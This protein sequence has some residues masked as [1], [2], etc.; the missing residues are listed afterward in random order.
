VAE[1]Y[2]SGR[3]AV[4]VTNT[5]DV[6]DEVFA[7]MADALAH[8]AHEVSVSYVTLPLRDPTG[9]LWYFAAPD[10]PF[11]FDETLV[12]HLHHQVREDGVRLDVLTLRPEDQARWPARIAT[13]NDLG[14]TREPTDAQRRDI[15]RLITLGGGANFSVPGAGKTG[16]TYTVYST[17][18][19]LGDVEQMLVL[20]PISAHETWETEP[21]LM[22]APGAAPRLHVGRGRP[23][24]AEVI[25][26]NY[27]RLENRGRLDALVS[28]CRRRRTFVVFDEAHRVKAGPHGIRGA[29]AIQL[30]AAAHRRSVLTGT[31][32]PNSPQDL[33][34]VLELAYPG[35]GFRLAARDADSLM[36]AYTRVTKD[37]LQLPPL[38]PFTEH[39]P[40]S[41]AHDQIY[42]AMVNAAARAVLRDPTLRSDFSRAGRIV[43]LLLQAATDPAA[44]LGADGELT[45]LS[46]RADLDLEHLIRELPASYLPTKFVRVAQ[47]VDGHW[48]D[49][50]KVVVWAN[51]RS[52]VRRLERLLAPHRP[53]MVSGDLARDLRQGE[54][55]RFRHDP[56]CHVLVAT[57]HTLSEG[58]SLHHTTT[59][60]IHLDRTFNAGML[61]QAIDRTHRLGLPLDADCTV[62]YLMAARRDGSDTIDDIA[63]RRLEAKVLDM[64][65]KLNDRQLATLAFP[66]ADDVLLD[67]DLLLGPGQRG[68]LEALFE[69]LQTLRMEP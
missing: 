42:E 12:E 22:Y 62:T 33:A 29:A 2:L 59:H 66:A 3:D 19:H 44:V 51:F 63:D 25:V 53:A 49:G 26:T 56:D 52:H 31:P 58:V 54:I 41:P 17:L 30:S 64:A 14:I 67:S 60:Q 45:M 27:E 47:H 32:Q 38:V 36:S 16:M 18:K 7:E 39:V 4:V 35:H 68:D 37:E 10:S 34:R 23:G 69:H 61:L 1:L 11:R 50:R 24:A 13:V 6:S 9:W 48:A 20:A 65:R 5:D 21:V 15:A 55:D 43:M 28:Y 46:D 57:P 40:L 8:I